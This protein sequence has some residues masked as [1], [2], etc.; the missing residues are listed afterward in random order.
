LRRLAVLLAAIVAA[1]VLTVTAAPPAAA[2]S[3]CRERVVAPPG[4]HPTEREI[5]L[6]VCKGDDV[7]GDFYYFEQVDL[8][9]GPASTRATGCTL[10]MWTTL[11]APGAVWNGPATF[12]DCRRTLRAS[13]FHIYFGRGSYT[14]ATNMTVHSCLTLWFGGR[15]GSVI[16]GQSYFGRV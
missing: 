13:D 12:H 1:G 5:V 2:T 15:K 8:Y 11:S 14:T 3:L 4:P 7:N 6:V 9:I 10:S 16:C